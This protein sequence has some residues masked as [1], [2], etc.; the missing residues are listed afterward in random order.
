MKIRKKTEKVIVLV[1]CLVSLVISP[2]FSLGATSLIPM[3]WD[4]F[5]SYTTGDQIDLKNPPVGDIWLVSGGNFDHF[6]V[7]SAPDPVPLAGG[8]NSLQTKRALASSTVRGITKPSLPMHE[9]ITAV[10]EHDI[11]LADDSLCA[12]LVDTGVTIFP[13]G[14]LVNETSPNWFYR[15][16]MGSVPG[17]YNS[18]VPYVR[19]TWIHM[20]LELFDDLTW[21]WTITPEGQPETIVVEKVVWADGGWGNSLGRHWIHP[22][23]PVI[24]EVEYWDNVQSNWFDHL[25]QGYPPIYEAPAGIVIDGDI[26]ATEWDGVTEVARKDPNS[27][28]N[29]KYWP[30]GGSNNLASDT[31]ADVHVAHDANNFYVS[32]RLTNAV[33]GLPDPNDDSRF[34]V[35]FSWDNPGK[36]NDAI[37]RFSI[38]A[39]Q[40]I[41]TMGDF[42]GDF[43]FGKLIRDDVEPLPFLDPLYDPNGNVFGDSGGQMS[44]SVVGGIL[45]VEMKIPFAAIPDFTGPVS[46]EKV[47]VQFN[48][49]DGTGKG[50]TNLIMQDIPWLSL[51]GD[52]GFGPATGIA[53]PICGDE[54]HPFPHGDLSEDCRVNLED[55]DLMAANWLQCTAPECD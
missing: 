13:A 3:F 11:Y 20:K 17:W 47:N 2:V 15:T 48:T 28:G 27:R 16:T 31:V 49:K 30:F 14:W 46:G 19:D 44:Y 25:A 26:G 35:V 23:N 39:H 32:H 37:Y 34:E 12:F 38:E 51:F 6:L 52:Q 18:G 1:V 41:A 21:T 33:T 55:I 42:P 54:D 53:F 8:L 7:A 24:G 29:F 22:G 10:F 9:G 36:V 50:T 43:S 45:E 5:E 4:D 40:P